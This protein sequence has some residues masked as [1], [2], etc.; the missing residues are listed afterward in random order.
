MVR[1]NRGISW[2]KDGA[3]PQP[4]T[5]AKIVRDKAAIPGPGQYAV[6]QPGTE[7]KGGVMARGPMRP[8]TPPRGPGP[9]EY[10]TTEPVAMK[11]AGLAQALESRIASSSCCCLI[12]T[13]VMLLLQM[14][15]CFHLIPIVPF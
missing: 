11:L 9:G 8:P 2:K 5:V 15:C 3:F 1:I 6:Q 7:P 4:G 12:N 10:V 14:F 13:A